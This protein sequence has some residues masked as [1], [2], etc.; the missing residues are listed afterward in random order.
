MLPCHALRLISTPWIPITVF[1]RIVPADTIYLSHRN[2]A[3]TIW[4]RILFGGGHYY[5]H[6]R[7]DTVAGAKWWNTNA[8]GPRCGHQLWTTSWLVSLF[9]NTRRNFA[10]SIRVPAFS[11]LASFSLG[12]SHTWPQIFEWVGA[13][14]NW[15]QILFHSARAI[16]RILFEGGYYSTCGYYSRKYGISIDFCA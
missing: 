11:I 8:C 4:G 10:S 13:D 16:V 1:P 15:G 2:N 3:N 9:P 7:D 5:F 14:T 12:A 6:A